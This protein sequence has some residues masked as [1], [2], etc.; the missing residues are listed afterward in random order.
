LGGIMRAH[1]TAGGGSTMRTPLA[2]LFVLISTLA[3]AAELT[4]ATFNTEFLTRPKVHMKFGLPLTLTGEARQQ[5][6][7]PGFRDQKFA[8]GAAEVAKVIADINADVIVLTE[9]GNERDV[10]E[11]NAAV[12]A[13]GVVYPHTA[14]CQCTDSQTQQH[15][16]VLSKFP[17]SAVLKAIPGREG[18]FKEFDDAESEDETA[19]SKGLMV[20]FSA[21]NRTFHLYGIHLASERGG[22]EQ[23][24]QR[25]AQ[26][27]IVRR[28]YLPRLN[29]GEHIIVAGDLNDGRGQPTLRRIQ[30]HDDIWPD[31]IQ[32]GNVQFFPEAELGSRWTY[33]FQGERNQ[34]DHIL[35]S[36]SI[37]DIVRRTRGIKSRVPEQANPRA[38]DHR[39]FVVTLDLL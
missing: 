6:E 26:A 34:I 39:P 7:V 38:S 29:M 37:R 14:V 28:H 12:Q 15:V 25:I 22:N 18:Y 30:G 23:D 32:T 9:V 17:L 16:A 3:N 33:E 2:T 21:G 20:T 11:L 31:L 19:L 1:R 24:Q 4:I 35:L 10:T 13:R 27:S 36:T 8:E 5:W